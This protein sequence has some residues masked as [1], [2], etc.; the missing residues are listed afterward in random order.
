M[1]EKHTEIWENIAMEAQ[2]VALDDEVDPV[3]RERSWMDQMSISMT[4]L[5]KL[6]ALPMPGNAPPGHT[7]DLIQMK[8][9]NTLN[10][11]LQHLGPNQ[12]EVTIQGYTDLTKDRATEDDG[13]YAEMMKYAAK[14][15]RIVIWLLVQILTTLCASPRNWSVT[16]V[17][18][19]WKQ[20]GDHSDAAGYL[21][22]TC[23]SSTN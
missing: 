19:V 6:P 4:L 21:P 18:L 22:I 14:P 3:I 17:C 1:H 16:N 23:L 9:T 11:F 15:M 2:A 5:V 13:I 10:T 8:W 12:L 20:K 7:A